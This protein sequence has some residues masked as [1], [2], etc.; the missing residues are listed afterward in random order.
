MK[1]DEILVSRAVS[2]RTHEESKLKKSQQKQMEDRRINQPSNA[3]HQSVAASGDTYIAEALR[4]VRESKITHPESLT[5][6]SGTW[7]HNQML[8]SSQEEK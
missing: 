8:N 4:K 1:K 5:R 2:Q 3:F 6:M 7:M